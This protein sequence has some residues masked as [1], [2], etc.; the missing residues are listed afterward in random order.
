MALSRRLFSRA[1][2]RIQPDHCHLAHNL[3]VSMPLSASNRTPSTL[4]NCLTNGSGGT[5][6]TLSIPACA[7][8][9]AKNTQAVKLQRPAVESG[10]DGHKLP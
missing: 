2:K 5:H 7:T 9:T 1:I 10:I 4:G 6:R 8:A 3:L